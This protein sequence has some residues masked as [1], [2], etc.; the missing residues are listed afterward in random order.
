[1]TLAIDSIPDVDS[2]CRRWHARWKLLAIFI[3][4][5]TASF[6][7]TIPMLAALA[8]LGLSV[9][10][11]AQL[12]KSWW[13]PRFGALAFAVA[14]FLIFLP[15]TQTNG[16]ELMTAFT[17]RVTAIALSLFALI[18]S[19]PVSMLMHAVQSWGVP[20]LFAQ[21]VLLAY[22]YT[23]LIADELARL[24]IA[25]R[26]RAFRNRMDRHSYRTVG[27]VTGCLLVRG[28]ERAEHVAQAMRCR[29][30]DGRFR[31][32]ETRHPKAI[33]R[34]TCLA[35]ALFCAVMLWLDLRRR[36]IA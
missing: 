15:L 24:R 9:F 12:P 31:T 13:L 7:Q 16:V 2:P 29:G 23:F 1:M 25:L 20:S 21:I 10:L 27:Q 36:G 18:G 17:L 33:D 19:T 22:R 8:T 34:I 3:M 5:M 30:F 28:S 6:T 26:V 14:P 32:L 4:V 35:I 11:A